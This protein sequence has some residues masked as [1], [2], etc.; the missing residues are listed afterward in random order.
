MRSLA[1][2]TSGRRLFYIGM[3]S[4]IALAGCAAMFDHDAPRVTVAGVEPIEG[5]VFELRFSVKLRVQNPNGTPISYDGVALD[6]DLNGKPFA[7]GVSD[8]RG[9]VA[10]FSDGQGAR[11][12]LILLAR[13]TCPLIPLMRHSSISRL[14]KCIPK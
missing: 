14:L 11:C 5:Q 1:A 8:Q 9:T 6:L 12:S 3:F 7:S 10:R 2:R 4:L 13:W